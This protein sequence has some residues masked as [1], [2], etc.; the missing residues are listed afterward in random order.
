MTK[1][2]PTD[3]TTIDNSTHALYAQTSAWVNSWASG[4]CHVPGTTA[5]TFCSCS[6]L[7]NALA[8][9]QTVTTTG[10]PPGGG[11]V[12]TRTLTVTTITDKPYQPPMACCSK[13]C[14]IHAS[15]IQIIYRHVDTSTRIHP[16]QLHQC[17]VPIAMSSAIS[18]SKSHLRDISSSSN[19]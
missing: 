10:T 9:L 1:P 8:Q 6:K 15:S 19:N 14:K 5:S 4:P 17:Q 16:S 7:F 11:L 12:W 13:T 2:F 18:H 3:T